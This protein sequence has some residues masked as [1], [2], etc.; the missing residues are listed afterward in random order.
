MNGMSGPPPYSSISKW[1][2]DALR[3]SKS[4]LYFA[5]GLSP[6]VLES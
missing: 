4:L 2:E 3:I 1:Y 6:R 5:P